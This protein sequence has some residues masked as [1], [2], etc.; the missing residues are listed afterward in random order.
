MTVEDGL[1]RPHGH[2]EMFPKAPNEEDAMSTLRNAGIGLALVALLT[3]QSVWAQAELT[4][5]ESAI[6]RD[7]V[8]R[9]PVDAN[10]TFASDVGRLYCW[11]RITGA[12]GE[13]TV[14]HVWI[15]GD[16]ERADLELRVGASPWR[17]WSNKAIVPEWTGDWRVEVRDAEGNVLETIRFTVGGI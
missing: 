13:T 10:T 11:T 7:V 3:P 1:G 8:D 17:T 4:V 2:V 16:E 5:T 12:E 15:H 14:H 6:S 9:M